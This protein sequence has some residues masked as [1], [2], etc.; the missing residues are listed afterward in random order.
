MAKSKRNKIV[1]LTQVKKKGKDHKEDLIKQVE[2]YVTQFKRVFIFDF[3]QTKSDRIMAL[4]LKLKQF[5]RIF[6][7]LNSISELTFNNIGKRTNTNYEQLV[8]QVVGKKGLLFTDL[9]KDKLMEILDK[10]LPEFCKKLVGYAHI[11]FEPE[12]NEEGSGKEV[13]LSMD[14]DRN[15]V[16]K[17]IVEK[18]DD[19]E[20][21]ADEEESKEKNSSSTGLKLKKTLKRK[22][23]TKKRM[24]SKK[25]EVMF[26]RI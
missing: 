16:E 9:S 21:E 4:R 26:V 15:D 7:G 5:G 25:R 3:D 6:A 18:G 11:S 13:E 24:K 14:L 23:K 12:E 2:Q 19:V 20:D 1:H 17:D 8:K 22:T 10:E